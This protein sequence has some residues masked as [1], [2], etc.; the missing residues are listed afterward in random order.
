MKELILV[1]VERDGFDKIPENE[2]LLFVKTSLFAD[3]INILLKLITFSNK[4][5]VGDQALLKAQNNQTIFLLKLLAGKLREGWDILEKDLWSSKLARDLESD[6]KEKGRNNLAKLKEYFKDCSDN[7]PI[8]L[9]RKKYAFHYD[10]EYIK[11][12][13]RAI[14]ID[15]PLDLYL[16]EHPYDTFYSISHMII[17]HSILEKVSKGDP[18]K[19]LNIIF[20]D[21]IKV[22]LWFIGLTFEILTI[23]RK[24]YSN[25]FLE[26]K[27]VRLDDV[28]DVND[29][30]IP[31]FVDGELKP[32]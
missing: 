22:A 8:S 4:E 20:N 24:K 28:P 3:E 27:L 32:I 23:I 1:K 16:A 25:V 29:I 19:A 7:N 12:Q 21:I 11:E 31:Y 9:I 6:L 15:E 13:L 14:S 18:W 5:V 17:N 30:F 10:S 2:K 26:A